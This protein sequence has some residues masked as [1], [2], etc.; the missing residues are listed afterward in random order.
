V[1]QAL[2]VV[3]AAQSLAALNAQTTHVLITVDG[4]P[5]RVTFDGSAPT[6]TNGHYWPAGKEEVLTKELAALMRVIRQT[7]AGTANVHASELTF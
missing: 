5:V 7:A 3:G 2:S 1:D 4:E 6:A